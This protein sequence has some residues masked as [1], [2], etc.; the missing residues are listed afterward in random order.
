MWVKGLYILKSKKERFLDLQCG[1]RGKH[2]HESRLEVGEEKRH[3]LGLELP[4]ELAEERACRWVDTLDHVEVEDDEAHLGA[5]LGRPVDVPGEP[6]G[7]PF[8]EEAL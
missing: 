5:P 2:R 8:E 1:V 6:R 3:R 4:V 7:R